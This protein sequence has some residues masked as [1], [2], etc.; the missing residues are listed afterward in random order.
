MVD[1]IPVL[2]GIEGPHE[3]VDHAVLVGFGKLTENQLPHLQNDLGVEAAED[4]QNWLDGH[5]I[6]EQ[7]QSGLLHQFLTHGHLT[8]GSVPYQ[9]YQLHGCPPPMRFF[10]C[11]STLL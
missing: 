7:P 11:S 4:L 3:G 8:Y 1:I 6:V 9:E 10:A 5:V 2:L